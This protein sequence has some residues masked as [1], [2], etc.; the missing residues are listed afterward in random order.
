MRSNGRS[1]WRINAD[2]VLREPL[3]V[4]HFTCRVL[5]LDLGGVA[6]AAPLGRPRADEP[7]GLKPEFE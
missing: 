5:K 4:R 6:D 1:S 7:Q 3:T 2:A